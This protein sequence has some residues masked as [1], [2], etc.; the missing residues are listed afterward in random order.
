MNL[1]TYTP[2]MLDWFEKRTQNHIN[3]VVDAAGKI[4]KQYPGFN[5]LISYALEHDHSK[6]SEPEKTPYIWIS[7]DKKCKKEG[8]KFE[9][10]QE[11]KD[12]M[13]E[14]TLHHI[15]GNAHHPEF[16]LENEKEAN[17]N[18]ENRDKSDHPVNAS[19]MNELAVAEM[20]C[21]WVAMSQ[22][23]KTNS[24]REWFEKCKDVRWIFSKQ[25]EELID[26]LLKVFE[27]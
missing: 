23:L 8:V 3:M 15:L 7:W 26:K 13:N 1:D 2:E 4:I 17:I 24:P 9:L 5:E 18:S 22:E 6:F 19:R 16:W 20:V 11:I 10:P 12:K 27:K 25:Q 21:D 14:I